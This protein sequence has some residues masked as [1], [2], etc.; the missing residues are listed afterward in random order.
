M[1]ELQW[2]IE[3]RCINALLAEFKVGE[4][5]EHVIVNIPD[6]NFDPSEFDKLIQGVEVSCRITE[7]NMRIS[8]SLETGS[9]SA[10]VQAKLSEAVEILE[11]RDLYKIKILK[12]GE[13]VSVNVPDM[14][15]APSELNRFLVELK[16]VKSKMEELRK[17][18]SHKQ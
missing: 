17:Q 4:K 11:E 2:V 16:S 14:L 12:T 15:F 9:V 18:F 8:K 3:V 13:I 6:R 7:E 1:A 10:P 5:G